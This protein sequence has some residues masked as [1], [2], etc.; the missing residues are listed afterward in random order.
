MKSLFLSLYLL[1]FQHNNR[2]LNRMLNPHQSLKEWLTTIDEENL[3]TIAFFFSFTPEFKGINSAGVDMVNKFLA[4]IDEY[5]EGTLESSNFFVTFKALFD[6]YFEDRS[7]EEG[8][9]KVEER[10]QS[11]LE[12]PE[13]KPSMVEH[14]L[15]M[16]A[17]L[18]ENKKIWFEIYKNWNDLKS[19]AL[20]NNNL[21][22]W[23]QFFKA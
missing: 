6:Y 20:S 5:A 13:I 22:A 15:K 11:L 9:R 12:H 23:G 7:N 21:K 8:W 16:K 3:N 19:N 17:Q 18:P 14:I 2:D 1:L 10:H 4:V